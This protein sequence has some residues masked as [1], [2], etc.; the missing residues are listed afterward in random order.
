M[1]A[2]SWLGLVL[3]AIGGAW[4]AYLLPVLIISGLWE[5]YL[6]GRALWNAIRRWPWSC[7]GY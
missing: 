7:Y 4:I 3:L 6:R 5:L 1:D 2:L